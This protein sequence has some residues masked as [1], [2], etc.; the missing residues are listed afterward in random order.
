MFIL[1]FDYYFI[2]LIYSFAVFDYYFFILRLGFLE[3]RVKILSYVIK[4]GLKLSGILSFF[5]YFGEKF[6]LA[7]LD[8]KI[9][10]CHY[11]CRLLTMFV[12]CIVK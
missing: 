6:N 8:I 2:N 5:I 12:L 3:H 11:F 4:C 7:I 10:S 9:L 1:L